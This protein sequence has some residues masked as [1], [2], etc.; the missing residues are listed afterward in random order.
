MKTFAKYLAIVFISLG[1]AFGAGEIY[2]RDKFKDPEHL[3][4]LPP[5]YEATFT[6]TPDG[7]PGIMGGPVQFRTNRWGLRG[8]DIPEDGRPVVY[9]MGGSTSIDAW[10]KDAWPDVMQRKLRQEAGLEH[11]IVLNISKW[12]L[13]T[14]HNLMHFKDVVPYLPKK[15]DVVVVLAGVNDMQRAVKSNVPEL[16]TPDFDRR[17]AYHY[18]PPKDTRWYA[19]SGLYRLYERLDEVRGKLRTGP[20]FGGNGEVFM[21][22]RKCRQAV[23]DDA[24]VETLPPLDQALAEYRSNLQTLIA[25][26]RDYGAD[27]I[28]AT[29]PSLWMHDMAPEEKRLLLSGAVS[30]FGRDD[31]GGNQYYSPAALDRALTAF[32]D[33]MR[34]VCRDAGRTCV[35]L[36]HVVPK[37]AKYYFDDVHFTEAGAEA[38]AS[39]VEPAVVQQLRNRAGVAGK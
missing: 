24:L 7:T 13:S 29:Q 33:M 3:H 8:G 22:L 36:D 11:A 26:A 23:P 35:D 9:V 16:V 21:P 4:V 37:K 15:P 25:N 17:V 38:V 30:A 18:I 14:H 12:G 31:C 32:N 19:R 20:L 2:L 1:V 5:L 6:P 39:A 10:L 27:I 28:F 34:S